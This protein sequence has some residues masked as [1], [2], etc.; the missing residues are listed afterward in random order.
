MRIE[1]YEYGFVLTRVAP[2][3]APY[4]ALY[5]ASFL[6]IPMDKAPKYM[7]MYLAEDN[8]NLISGEYWNIFSA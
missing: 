7:F 5:V 4:V 8:S 2:Y 3:V 1:S 6:S